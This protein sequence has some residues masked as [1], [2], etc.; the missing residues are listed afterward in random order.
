MDKFFFRF[1]TIVSFLS[2]HFITYEKYY[3]ETKDH[4]FFIDTNMRK[5]IEEN[6]PPNIS[7]YN[8][9]FSQCTNEKFKEHIIDPL[10]D[11]KFYFWLNYS[12]TLR[13]EKQLI[14]EKFLTYF[15]CIEAISRTKI[16]P[17]LCLKENI[18]S[19]RKK[20]KQAMQEDIFSEDEIEF[21]KERISNG[22]RKNIRNILIELVE[23]EFDI[24]QFKEYDYFEDL[25][26]FIKNLT[27]LRHDLSHGNVIRAERLDNSLKDI[28]TL[29]EIVIILLLREQGINKDFPLNY[30]GFRNM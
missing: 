30:Y 20:V 11:E 25:T 5:I 26:N 16:D 2:N 3:V 23:N 22:N 19:L 29:K 15:R 13:F 21:V 28:F 27:K 8:H 1:S 17:K 4:I 6:G 10:L 18:N 9:R 7:R 12:S 24:E 14:E